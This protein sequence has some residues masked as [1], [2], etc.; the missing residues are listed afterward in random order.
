M[1]LTD[2]FCFLNKP[3]NE[4]IKLLDLIDKHSS[5][6]NARY[7]RMKREDT[8]IVRHF[9]GDA[10]YSIIGRDIYYICYITDMHS[11]IYVLYIYSI[12]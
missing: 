5:G 11:C 10:M 3:V 9:A 7:V 4:D 12:L 1:K 2:E 8:F 6:S